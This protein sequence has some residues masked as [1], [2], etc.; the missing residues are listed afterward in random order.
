M[1]KYIGI[2]IVFTAVL[3]SEYAVAAPAVDPRILKAQEFEGK[4]DFE[5]AIAL[6]LELYAANKQDVVFYKLINLYTGSEDYEGLETLVVS[7]LKDNPDHI[8]AKLYLARSYYGRGENEKGY[9]LLLDIIGDNWN[10]VQ[11]VRIVANELF[12]RNDYDKA[13]DIYATAREKIGS[14]NLFAYELARIYVYREDYVSAIKEYLKILDAEKIAYSN[15]KSVIESAIN[16]NIEINTLVTLFEDYLY[17]KPDSINAA[18]LLS[19]LLYRIGDFDRAYSMLSGT[20]VKTDSAQDV[21]TFAEM[22]RSDNHL[23]K[24][25]RAYRD[26]YRN[27]KNAPN[28]VE[29]LET[30]ASIERELGRPEN[31][32]DDYQQIIDS[33]SGTIEAAFAGLHLLELS[34]DRTSFE[35]YARILEEYAE[36]S[37]FREVTHEAYYILGDTFLRNGFPDKAATAFGNALLNARSNEERYKIYVISA[38]L[39]FFENNFEMMSEEIRLCTGNLPDGEDINDLLTYKILGLRCSTEN[40]RSAYEAF[41]K[42]HCALYCG[43]RET[44]EEYFNDASA[45][46]STVVAPHALSALGKISLS[47]RNFV[48][49]ADLYMLAAESAQDTTIHVEALIKAAD[50]YASELNDKERAKTLYL[51]TI[52]SFPGTVFEHELRK[53]LRLLT[54]QNI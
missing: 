54:D 18:R 35:G 20:A 2:I 13:I 32:I 40:D 38:Y 34:A 12:V 22:L 6:Y 47:K 8:E 21:W 3:A 17:N 41:S 14:P 46:T 15:I 44:A 42:G 24:A 48:K 27:F 33:H 25:L 4:G 19:E 7:K 5:R 37:E 23:E 10:E 53:K 39:H 30:S 9:E 45:D 49:A 50:I 11:K 29:A 43:D 28:L 31:A 52:T 36:N 16:T 26:Y 1:K 51:D